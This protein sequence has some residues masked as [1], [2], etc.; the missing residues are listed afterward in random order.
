MPNMDT[1]AKLNTAITYL[2]QYKQMLIGASQSVPAEADAYLNEAQEGIKKEQK[3]IERQKKQEE[4]D[5]QRAAKKVADDAKKPAAPAPAPAPAS[6]GYPAA[7][8]PRL[9]LDIRRH[10]RPH[11][12][13]TRRHPR[14]RR[15]VQHHPAGQQ[16]QPRGGHDDAFFA[17]APIL[18]GQTACSLR[19]SFPCVFFL[20]PMPKG[21]RRRLRAGDSG[22]SRAR[23]DRFG[24]GRA[25][26][27]SERRRRSDKA[28]VKVERGAG[29]RK[30]YKIEGEIVIEGK[31]QK[32]EAFY[33]LQKS[34]INYDWHE[35]K[36]EFVPKILDSV[37]K[38]P[39]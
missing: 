25:T 32:P 7:P 21:T 31:I 11:L 27:G 35:L 33:V 23:Q 16:P 8:L 34:G 18:A 37:T 13:P 22:Q 29:G 30:V 3:R 4:R 5:R 38:A 17:Q 36:Q 9:R 15:Q 39:F 10:P 12:A 6:G 28:K 14:P 2:Q 19:C 26:T 20:S 24:Q 1:T